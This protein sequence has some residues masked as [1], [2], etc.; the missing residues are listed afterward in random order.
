MKLLLLSLLAAASLPAQVIGVSGTLSTWDATG[1]VMLHPHAG[2]AVAA[3]YGT[4]R[5]A[6][7]GVARDFAHIT[8]DSRA[9]VDGFGGV[10]G[11]TTRRLLRIGI[12]AR[13]LVNAR[14]FSVSAGVHIDQLR[15]Y[16]GIQPSVYIS[17]EK[18]IK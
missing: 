5:T 7:L 3:S 9:Y 6:L 13:T 15:G 10:T 18:V 2:W 1:A 8:K 4:G 12:G 11:N 16:D 14:G 17:L